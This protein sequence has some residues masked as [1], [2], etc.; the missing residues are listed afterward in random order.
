MKI[1]GVGPGGAP[2]TRRTEKSG[3]EKSAEFAR[4]LRRFTDEARADDSRPVDA[5]S[6]LGGLDSLL[7]LQMVDSA[8]DALDSPAKRKAIVQRGEDILDRLEELRVGL[9]LGSIPKERLASLAQLVR[10]RRETAQ[11]P[12]LGALLDE[13]EL[14][15]EVELAKLSRR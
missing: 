1:S 8:G 7:A 9:L 5:P 15:A 13:I 4:A 12:Q 3:K 10:D 6:N 14:R 2:Q 11:D